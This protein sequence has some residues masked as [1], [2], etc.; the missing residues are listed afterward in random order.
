VNFQNLNSR[1]PKKLRKRGDAALQFNEAVNLSK[2]VIFIA[3]PKTGTTSIRQQLR[4]E[5]EKLI[6]NPH[7]TILQVRDGLYTYFLKCALGSNR[8]FP[9][10]VD[11][12]PDDTDI[13]R[14]A[15][16]T[17]ESFFKFASV[18]NPWA[19][20]VSLYKRGEGVQV[21]A[22]MSFTKFC[23]DLHYASDTS[24]HPT[25]AA[26][27]L[28]WLVDET[29]ALAVD[30]VLKLEELSTGIPEINALTGGR[31]ALEQRHANRNPESMAESYRDFYTEETQQIV[32]DLFKR[33]I[34]FFG[35]SY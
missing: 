30:Y 10:R 5:G 11:E 26:C 18:R 34:E 33:D 23:Q 17:F 4:V 19:R 3:I 13:R 24:R 28:D 25:R 20:A 6:P 32:G 22:D 35:Y 31:M 27:Q 8:H 29:G 14:Q 1:I 16:D 9:T 21:S 7:L 12:V 15:A 2:Q